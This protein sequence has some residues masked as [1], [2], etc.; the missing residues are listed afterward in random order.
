MVR[1][2]MREEIGLSF[3][4]YCRPAQR[5][6]D[7]GQTDV[8]QTE[9]IIGDGAGIRALAEAGKSVPGTENASWR[10]FASKNALRTAP[11]LVID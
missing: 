8:G 4:Q 6:I 2:L 3:H 9:S 7:V 1:V 10:A 5:D 11:V